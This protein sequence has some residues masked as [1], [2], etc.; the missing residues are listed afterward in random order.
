MDATWDS[1]S[2][3]ELQAAVDGEEYVRSDLRRGG[4]DSW[5]AGE[6]FQMFIH[7][8]CRIS[9]IQLSV[10]APVDSVTNRK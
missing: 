8:M 6:Y 2:A 5:S 1:L 9:L 4:D 10:V 3:A 7:Y